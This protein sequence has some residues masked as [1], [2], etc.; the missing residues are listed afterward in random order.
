M[1]LGH[2]WASL[3]QEC[4]NAAYFENPYSNR[5]ASVFQPLPVE[6]EPPDIP[7]ATS[8]QCS[9]VPKLDWHCRLGRVRNPGGGNSDSMGC[10][11]FTDKLAH[12]LR[13]CP[14]LIVHKCKAPF[15]VTSFY[16]KIGIISGICYFIFVPS[17]VSYSQK[18]I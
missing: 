10:S 8:G 4:I 6:D 18:T 12:P 3:V 7:E 9:R 5:S 15:S 13:S 2:K 17:P 1:M 16:T 14:R 11:V